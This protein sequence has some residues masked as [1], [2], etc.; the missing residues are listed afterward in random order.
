MTSSTL[1]ESS[2]GP[3]S[4][5]VA[6]RRV[7][8]TGASGFVGSHI[9]LELEGAGAAPVGVVRNPQK[10]AWLEERGVA[11]RRADLADVDAMTVAFEGCDA[12]VANAALG[13]N[14]GSLD[15][16]VRANTTGVRNTF[17]AA[18]RAG[19]NRVVYISSVAVYNNRPLRWQTEESPRFDTDAVA[20]GRRQ[21]SVSDLTTDWRYAHSKALAEELAWSE[22]ERLGLELT[23]LRPG[24]V[25]GSRDPKLMPRLIKRLKLPVLPLPRV[26]MP[27]VHAGDVAL[28]VVGAL[29]NPT[30]VGQAYNLSG[31][32]TPLPEVFRELV[33]QGASPGR[34]PIILSLPLPLWVG[35]DTSKAERDLGFRA[36]SL[37]DGFA[38]A[39]AEPA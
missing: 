32:P 7:A 4:A 11:L 30:S 10:A 24:P 19:V 23:S 29:K 18:A 35:F 1:S 16:L 2:A 13:S 22:A 15:E 20:A 36:R 28:A 37:K 6:G 38:E 8:V 3:S 9:A 12:V 27:L 17:A 5:G 31:P 33:R 14:Q 39:L 21:L 34:P 25:Y 26:G